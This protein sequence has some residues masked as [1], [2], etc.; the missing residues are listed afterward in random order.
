MVTGRAEVVEVVRHFT[1]KRSDRR[2]KSGVR[3]VHNTHRYFTVEADGEIVKGLH[4][5][6]SQVEEFANGWNAAIDR[7]SAQKETGR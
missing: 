7:I 3:A 6:R 2:T 1:E 4:H 5:S